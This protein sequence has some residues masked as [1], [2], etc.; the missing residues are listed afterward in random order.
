MEFPV[1]TSD[2]ET[3]TEAG[4]YSGASERGVPGPLC[5]SWTELSFQLNFSRAIVQRKMTACQK[6]S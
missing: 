3:T 5:E 4:I 1:V 6:F 2:D